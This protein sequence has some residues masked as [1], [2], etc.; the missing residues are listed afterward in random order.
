MLIV[1][2]H[3][4]RSKESIVLLIDQDSIGSQVVRFVFDTIM[5]LKNEKDKT[6]KRHDACSSSGRNIWPWCLI[7]GGSSSGRHGHI[8]Q[9]V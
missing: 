9:R 6:K 4:C 1:A 5:T 8:V 3:H 7:L 2:M